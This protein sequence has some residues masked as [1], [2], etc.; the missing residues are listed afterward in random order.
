MVYKNHKQYRLPGYDY[1]SSGD[2]FI[3]I[4]THNRIN[5]FGE[6]SGKGND[7][8]MHL[9]PIGAKAKEL[10]LKIPVTYPVAILG[11]WEVMP[12][13]VHLIISINKTEDTG[14]EI[15]IEKCRNIPDRE[16]GLKPLISGSVS[17]IVNHYKGDVKKWCNKNDFSHFVWQSKF[18]DHI[19]R[20]HVSYNR[21]CNYIANNI[22][23][24]D[25]DTL[26]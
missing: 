16:R 20:N 14:T 18:H 7:A 11:E 15:S 2:Y 19:I 4:C 12:N 10:I 8:I 26:K 1:S 5:Y 23:N 13:H 25:G 3:T 22:Y 6:I 17:S 9:S 21:I 24:W